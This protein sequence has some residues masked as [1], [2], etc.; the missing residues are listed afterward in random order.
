MNSY[1]M[2]DGNTAALNTWLLDQDQPEAET[3]Y[4]AEAKPFDGFTENEEK[5]F[6]MRAQ[7]VSLFTET[8]DSMLIGA[9]RN[10]FDDCEAVAS[11]KVVTQLMT[12]K[13][14]NPTDAQAAGLMES[15]LPFLKRIAYCTED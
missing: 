12:D 9:R 2:E 10:N 3:P 4:I 1:K 7:S 6:L 5:A 14:F 13:D 11:L 15:M 8:I